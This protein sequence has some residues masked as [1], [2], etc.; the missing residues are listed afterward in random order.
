MSYGPLVSPYIVRSLCIGM[1][2]CIFIYMDDLTVC[3]I[4]TSY[5]SLYHIWAYWFISTVYVS[6]FSGAKPCPS[7]PI[8]ELGYFR[9]VY[10]LQNVW[11]YI[12]FYSFSEFRI[13]GHASSI[14]VTRRACLFGS[15][16][17]CSKIE[18]SHHKFATGYILY[19]PATYYWRRLTSVT[20]LQMLLVYMLLMYFQ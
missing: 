15:N 10:M 7:W 12:S 1:N 19:I 17:E 4:S 5:I 11:K 8:F 6:L 13:K 20:S 14:R 2:E 18:V 3:V 9:R 16:A